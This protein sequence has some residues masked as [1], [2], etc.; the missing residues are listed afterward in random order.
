MML[1]NHRPPT[2]LGA[3]GGA[4]GGSSASKKAPAARRNSQLAFHDRTQTFIVFDWDDT[5]F[6]TTY[7]QEGLGL[8]WRLPLDEQANLTSSE[9]ADAR[10]KLLTC[11]R[12]AAAALTRAAE[13]AHVVVITLAGSGWVDLS[14]RHFY[15]SLGHLLR[16]LRIPV[17]YAQ[18]QVKGLPQQYKKKNFQADED[19]ERYWGLVK[20]MAIAEEA[21]R[22]YSQ[23]EG[24]SWKNILSIGDATFERYG[25]L[26]AASAYMSDTPLAINALGQGPVVWSPTQEGC[27]EKVQNGHVKKLRAKCC[28]LVDQ[29]DTEELAVQLEMVGKWL[30]G[31]VRLNEGFDLDLEAV[32]T[33][34]QV[35]IIEAVFRGERPVSDLPRLPDEPELDA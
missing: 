14:C 18:E 23:Y 12:Y 33:E 21:D 24:Q 25:L 5:I 20:G 4:S 30:E 8:D 10:Q 17:I 13:L 35:P 28:K 32:E 22:F 2:A 19:Q 15:P 11:E 16:E 27:W 6:P 29:P 7:V 34:A 31:M 26:A 3:A 1:A 9:V